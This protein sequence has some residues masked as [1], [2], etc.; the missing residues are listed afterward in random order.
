MWTSRQSSIL[1][2]NCQKKLKEHAPFN[3]RGLWIG[4][5]KLTQFSY[6]L[7][8][9]H[10]IHKVQQ[11]A[12]R[13]CIQKPKSQTGRQAPM[14]SC[15]SPKLPATFKTRIYENVQKPRKLVFHAFCVLIVL[16]HPLLLKDLPISHWLK[17]WPFSH[18]MRRVQCRQKH[19]QARRQ[20]LNGTSV[21][22]FFR[23]QRIFPT[24][25]PSC[26]HQG[27]M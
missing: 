15:F 12:A 14:P 10:P 8:F 20:G 5:L 18:S 11:G 6:F 1:V 13:H 19:R 21:S 2:R 26:N 27:A 17:P 9:K 22:D 16:P 25:P 24:L 4:K 23:F 3:S 7:E